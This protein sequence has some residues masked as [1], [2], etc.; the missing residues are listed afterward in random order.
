MSFGEF[1]IEKGHI[2]RKQLIQGW[3]EQESIIG[4]PAK[5]AF[6]NSLVPEDQLV[7]ILDLSARTGQSFRESCTALNIWTHELNKKLNQ[8]SHIARLPIG[9]ILVKQRSLPLT[10]MVE[11][12]ED[13]SLNSNSPIH[14][15]CSLFG[16]SERA[17]ISE[18]VDSLCARALQGSQGPK[19][20]KVFEETIGIIQQ[21]RI[22]FFAARNLAISADSPL[23][24]E[25]FNDVAKLLETLEKTA[26]DPLRLRETDYR[27][28][29]AVIQQVLRITRSLQQSLR[30]TGNEK[31]FLASPEHQQRHQLVTSWVHL[32][33]KNLEKPTK[34]PDG[35]ADNQ[36]ANQM[37]KTMPEL[38]SEL[39]TEL[40]S[41][42][43]SAIPSTTGPLTGA[44]AEPASE[45]MTE[46][47]ML[48][49]AT[50]CNDLQPLP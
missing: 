1:L 42:T 8:L 37:A 49:Q 28:V 44:L 7:Q 14:E 22:C 39:L 33:I 40:N 34:Q 35:Q 12:F 4:S 43:G 20:P 30:E 3:I 16:D 15:Y 46:M 13:Y 2:T 27:R 5:I 17:E 36:M 29:A 45:P 25:L 18:I 10:Q 6:E 24:A 9:Q 11:A 26:S 19:V 23:A 47:Q 31:S 21:C 50:L 38:I 32:L 48:V 41:A